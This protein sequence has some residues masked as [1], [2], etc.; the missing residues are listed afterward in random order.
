MKKIIMTVLFSATFTFATAEPTFFVHPMDFD[1]TEA[2]NYSVNYFV[3]EELTNV[4]VKAQLTA[5]EALSHEKNRDI[6]NE[7]IK[8]ACDSNQCDYVSIQTQ[9]NNL[10]Q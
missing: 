7:A 1:N 6:M 8:A 3:N 10:L 2:I 5:F 9:Y 4:D